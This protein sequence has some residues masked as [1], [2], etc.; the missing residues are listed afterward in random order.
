MKQ[1]ASLAAVLLLWVWTMESLYYNITTFPWHIH[2]Q[3]QR[4]YMDIISLYMD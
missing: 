1:Y 2:S 4:Q 3:L